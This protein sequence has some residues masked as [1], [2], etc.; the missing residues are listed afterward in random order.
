MAH[1]RTYCM[2]QL[3]RADVLLRNQWHDY[4]WVSHLLHL[5][6]HFAQPVFRRRNWYDDLVLIHL[7]VAHYLQSVR[8][9]SHLSHRITG[10]WRVHAGRLL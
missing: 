5:H 2:D 1:I 4:L 9:W 7:D 6:L 3:L 10:L 8:P